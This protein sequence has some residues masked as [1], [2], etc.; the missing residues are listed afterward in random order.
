MSTETNKETNR[1]APSFGYAS[2][3][4]LVIIVFMLVGIV[5]FKVPLQMMFFLSWLIVIPVCMKLGYSFEELEEAAYSMIKKALQPM[6]ILLTV[7]AMIGA[8]IASGTVPTIIYGGLKVITPQFFLLTAL[9]L[10]S[11]TS[12]AT[13]TSW[14]TMGTTG[15]AMVGIGTGLGIPVGITAGA[16]ICGAYFGDKMSPLSDSTVLAPAVSGAK[17]MDHIKHMLYTTTPA[18]LISAILFTIIGFKYAGRSLDYENINSILNAIN[19]H[20][21]IGIIPVI[22]AIVLITLLVMKRPAVTSILIGAVAGAV[23]AIVYQGVD[24]G[25]TLTFM[26]NGFQISSGDGFIDTLLN[27]GGV[28]SMAGNVNLFLFSFGFAGM[29]KEAGM[30]DAILAPLTKKINSVFSLVGVTAIISYASNAIG[31]SMSFA[32]IMAGT[33]MSPLYKE[34]K[35]KPENL[36]RCIEDFGTLGAVLIPWNGNAVFASTMLGATP[37]QFVPYCFLNYLCPIISLFYAK[38]GIAMTKF[39]NFEK[40]KDMAV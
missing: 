17:L 19:M 37:G 6:V 21:K 36:S 20:F 27:R 22:P 39:D 7:G 5:G 38:T 4:M 1:I 8:W 18:Y 13:G 34:Y 15:L 3:T 35:L 33:L 16:V 11:I 31:G 30:L 23:V 28:M 29:M 32:A 2:G 25:Q 24:I 40:T 12:I 9:L 14:G 10:C 26:Y